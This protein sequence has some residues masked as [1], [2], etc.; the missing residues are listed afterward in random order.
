MP[1]RYTLTFSDSS[2][3]DDHGT[4]RI[5][6]GFLIFYPRWS[7]GPFQQHAR[8]SIHDQCSATLEYNEACMTCMAMSHMHIKDESAED[9]YINKYMNNRSVVD[10]INTFNETKNAR[11]IQSSML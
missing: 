3:D 10:V 6:G 4:S 7:S 1:T 9:K 8:I 5:T 2:W 11:Y